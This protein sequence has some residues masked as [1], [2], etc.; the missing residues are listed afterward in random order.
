MG[1]F[2]ALALFAIGLLMGIVATVFDVIVFGTGSFVAHVS[3]WVLVNA[4]FSSHIASRKTAVLWSIPFNLGY[5]EC[6]YLTTAASYEGYA[7]ALVVPLAAMALIGPALSCAL[8]TAKQERNAYGRI[9]ALLIVAGTLGS[10]Y[11]INGALSIYDGVVCVLTLLVILVWPTRRFDVTRAA[12]KDL[13]QRL[14]RVQEPASGSEVEPAV[15]SQPQLQPK[16]D[17]AKERRQDAPQPTKRKRTRAA[18]FGRRKDRDDSDA[19]RREKTRGSDDRN[20]N[21]VS[22]DLR[23]VR[24]VRQDTSTA[25]QTAPDPKATHARSTS[26]LG[27]A[28]TARPSSRSRRW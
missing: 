5:I 23:R 12:T 1:V 6:Y 13:R 16:D 11:Y 15:E 26:P 18:L 28:K 3:L 7:K 9:L 4:L 14:S 21:D 25:S 27:T 20:R 22:R 17:R 24:K 8:W 19:G 10:S 2:E